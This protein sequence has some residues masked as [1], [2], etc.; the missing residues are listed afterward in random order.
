MTSSLSPEKNHVVR[1]TLDRT[2]YG[3]DHDHYFFHFMKVPGL[4]LSLLPLASSFLTMN[5]SFIAQNPRAM[6]AMSENKKEKSRLYPFKEARKIARGHGFSSKEEFIAYTC[7]GAYQLPKNPDEVW[8]DDWK[9]WD[10]FLGICHE[11]ASGRDIARC[12]NIDSKE[13]YMKLFEDKKLNEDD[14]A[15]RLPYR[16]DLKYRHE[17]NGWDDWLEK[18]IA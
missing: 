7:P 11:F 2:Q 6:S 8:S 12:L 17:W 5:S 16:P 14:P 1:K 18:P 10:D 9:G 4:V 13:E 3:Q 15:S